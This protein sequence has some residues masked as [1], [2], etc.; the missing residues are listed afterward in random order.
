LVWPEGRPTC[1]TC[2]TVRPSVLDRLRFQI[3]FSI[4]VAIVALLITWLL[5]GESSPLAGLARLGQAKALWRV[6]VVLP[7]LFSAVIAGNPHS[8]PP[9]L[10]IAGLLL[11]W[12]IVG[13]LVS[14]P[15][16]RRWSRHGKK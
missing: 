4:A 13:F 11:Q 7:L 1:A 3:V 10:L 2:P 14:I 5:L 8:P 9:A 12:L 15:V 16:A 6:T